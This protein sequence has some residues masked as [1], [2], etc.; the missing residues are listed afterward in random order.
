MIKG[1]LFTFEMKTNN[2]SDNYLIVP[3]LFQIPELFPDFPYLADALFEQNN[4]PAPGTS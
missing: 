1:S 3:R 4:S 2:F